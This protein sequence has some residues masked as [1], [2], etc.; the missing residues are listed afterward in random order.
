M[1]K[2]IYP[3]KSKFKLYDEN[4]RQ[5]YADE[6][7]N[8]R[9]KR[10]VEKIDNYTL[11]K[12]HKSYVLIEDSSNEMI[13]FVK[14]TFQNFRIRNSQI[15]EKIKCVKHCLMY[16]KWGKK[17]RPS[18]SGL[19]SRIFFNYIFPKTNNFITDKSH[20]THAVNCCFKIVENSLKEGLFVYYIK[21]FGKIIKQIHSI[22][23][24]KNNKEEIW[25]ER[26][27]FKYRTLLITKSPLPETE[28]E[29]S[30]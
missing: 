6:V 4:W 24:L 20:T 26:E 19:S 12:F 23:E 9:S 22:E 28:N 25:G 11:Y 1:P 14:Y 10:I 13:F 15:D 5:Q 8:S 27:R 3:N 29:V 7:V 21:N 2:I 30:F 18:T 17:D 16:S